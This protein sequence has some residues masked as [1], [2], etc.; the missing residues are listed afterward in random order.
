M[1]Y[2]DFVQSLVDAET[3]DDRMAL[4]E[5]EMKLYGDVDTSKLNSVQAELEQAKLDLLERERIIA[6]KDKKYK[7]RF[8]GNDDVE[9][10]DE[11][12]QQ[13]VKSLA[14]LGYGK[15]LY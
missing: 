15:R 5:K 8:F 1:A 11:P 4:A 7:D 6:E 10:D 14:D 2:K 13:R 3:V 9:E 12:E